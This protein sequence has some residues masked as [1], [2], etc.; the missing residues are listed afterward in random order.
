MDRNAVEV[1][2]EILARLTRF[3]RVHLREQVESTNDYAF[4]LADSREPALVI[5]RRQTRGRGRFRRRWYS[6][7]SSLLFSLLLFPGAEDHPL[8]AGGLALLAGLAVSRGIEDLTGT[9]PL[10]RWPNDVMLDDRKLCGILCEQ[11]REALVVGIGINVNQASFPEMDDL[12][13]AGSL[14]LATNRE[15]ERLELLETILRRLFA[16]LEQVRRDGLPAL[17]DEY[18]SRSAVLHRRVEAK[19]ALRRHI[20]TV[21][22]IDAEGRLVIRRDNGSIVTVNSGQVRRLR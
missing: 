19:T 10:I 4:S 14:R 15:W 3:G 13:E 2:G 1:P 22:D 5:A 7:D 20:G 18:K 16:A 12:A 21:V 6:D 11:R 8:P 17:M 9:R